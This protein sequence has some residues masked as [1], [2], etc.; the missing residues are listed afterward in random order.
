[1]SFTILS[2]LISTRNPSRNRCVSS[3]SY[4]TRRG[5]GFLNC[6]CQ[7]LDRRRCRLYSFQRLCLVLLG[8]ASHDRKNRSDTL[9]RY[10]PINQSINLSIDPCKP[11]GRKTT[12]QAKL[13]LL[14]L[15]VVFLFFPVC[16]FLIWATFGTRIP[17]THIY[18]YT[19]S[20]SGRTSERQRKEET[21]QH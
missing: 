14:L 17:R 18:I 6:L 8:F 19:Y 9:F 10:A 21:R 13:L 7:V 2:Y 12:K 16:F 15:L 5:S 4:F 11:D 3:P 1:M 20:Y